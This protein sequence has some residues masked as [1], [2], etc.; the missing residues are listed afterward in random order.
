MRPVVQMQSLAFAFGDAEFAV[1]QLFQQRMGHTRGAGPGSI[2][3]QHVGRTIFDHLIGDVVLVSHV[4]TL[5]GTHADAF[6]FL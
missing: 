2:H 4:L 6:L 1:F 3:E 5:V